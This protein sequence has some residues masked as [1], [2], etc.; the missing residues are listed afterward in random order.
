MFT[1]SLLQLK[2]WGS[3][4]FAVLRADVLKTFIV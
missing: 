3:D 1:F 4:V 2:F